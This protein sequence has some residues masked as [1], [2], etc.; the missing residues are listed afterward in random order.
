MSKVRKSAQISRFD[1]PMISGSIR[2]RVIGSTKP[3]AD[4]K[5]F[6][7][8]IYGNAGSELTATKLP[9]PILHFFSSWPRFSM[10]RFNS[11]LIQGLKRYHSAD[12]WEEPVVPSSNRSIKRPIRLP[13]GRC[14][15]S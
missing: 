10:S 13:L 9:S 8:E 11:C 6:I 1:Y 12:E 5:P 14:L 7:C 4:T 15:V 2:N 3:H